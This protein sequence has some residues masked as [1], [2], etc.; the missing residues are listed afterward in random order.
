MTKTVSETEDPNWEQR[1]LVEPLHHSTTQWELWEEKGV[2]DYVIIGRTTVSENTSVG[3]E[4]TIPLNDMKGEHLTHENGQRSKLTVVMRVSDVKIPENS[5]NRIPTVSTTT[6]P[7]NEKH[8][9]SQDKPR[10]SKKDED[11]TP[12][13]SKHKKEEEREKS[14]EKRKE[15][16]KEKKKEKAK[17]EEQK[18]HKKSRLSTENRVTDYMY[19]GIRKRGTISA[20]MKS[21]KV[22]KKVKEKAKGK[23]EMEDKDPQCA[24]IRR[25]LEQIMSEISRLKDEEYQD[26][27]DWAE[28]DINDKCECTRKK[29]SLATRKLA[30]LRG[31]CREQDQ[32]RDEGIFTWKQR[33]ALKGYLGIGFLRRQ[34]CESSA[35]RKC[36]FN[37]NCYNSCC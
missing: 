26:M 33:A 28:E 15:K 3:D 21:L 16:E 34:K 12:K 36:V 27:E 24:R 20:P 19:N 11:K 37:N 13:A 25:Q 29:L 32:K 30:R 23:C 17:K 10:K 4:H 22:K 5:P 7:K 18:H 6:S 31:D 35:R 2:R 14:K 9:E 8:Q 1:F